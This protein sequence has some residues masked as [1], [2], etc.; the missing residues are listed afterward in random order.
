[1][2]VTAI[3]CVFFAAPRYQIPI[4]PYVLLFAAVALDHVVRARLDAR[5]QVTAVA[6]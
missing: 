2:Y 5:R 4:M 6:S 1:V 3:H